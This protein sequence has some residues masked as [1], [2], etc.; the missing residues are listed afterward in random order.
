LRS[1][2]ELMHFSKWLILQ[3]FVGF[4]KARASD[5]VIGRVAGP[6]A[7]G[8]FSVAAEISN[9]PGT[10]LVAPINRAILPAYMNLAKDPPALQR[11]FLSVM[12]MVALLGVPAVAGLAVCAPFVVLLLLGPKWVQTGDIIEILAFYGITQ[13]MQ[14]NAYSAFLALGKPQVFVR[15]TTINVVILVTLLITLTPTHGLTGAAWAYVGAAV[16]TL[17]IDFYFITR[18]MGLRPRAYASR[19]WRPLCGAA[20]MYGGIRALGP[21]LPGLTVLPALESA[22]SLAVCI[23]MGVPIYVATVLLL[24]LLSGQP[25]ATAESWMIDRLKRLLARIPAA[26]S[27]GA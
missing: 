2:G 23:A 24:W 3:N 8:I 15:I 16:I 5:F 14:S 1:V 9:M 26:P 13:V 25:K 18:H 12:S 6:S 22:R 10:E 21:A 7:L 17:P 11:E 27:G 19:L 4:L 20:L